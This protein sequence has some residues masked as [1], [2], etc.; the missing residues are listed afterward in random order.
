MPLS[1]YSRPKGFGGEESAVA[2]FARLDGTVWTTDKDGVVPA[3]LV[4]EITARMNRD[5]SEV[6]HE[7]TREFGEPV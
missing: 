7:L 3:L 1:R 5:P 4:A 6:C 2:S